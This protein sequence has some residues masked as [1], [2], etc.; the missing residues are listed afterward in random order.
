MEKDWRYILE[1]SHSK[2]LLVSK[3]SIYEKT[4]NFV[5]SVGSV[6]AV[7]SMDAS[8]DY[9]HSYKRWMKLVATEPALEPVQPS[10]EDVL[11]LIYTSGT[12]GNICKTNTTS[13]FI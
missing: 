8:I 11:V 12:T 5:G 2:L 6:Q 10:I 1:D 13:S 3:E 9:M 4:K 7:L